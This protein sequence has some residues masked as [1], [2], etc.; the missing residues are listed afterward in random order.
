MDKRPILKCLSE[1]VIKLVNAT[2]DTYFD[3]YHRRLRLSEVPRNLVSR[4]DKHWMILSTTWGYCGVAFAGWSRPS[5]CSRTDAPIAILS[6]NIISKAAEFYGVGRSLCVG[7]V[8]ESSRLKIF[9]DSKLTSASVPVFLGKRIVKH[10][11][12]SSNVVPVLPINCTHVPDYLHISQSVVTSGVKE[13]SK[14]CHHP[15]QKR[16]IYPII[17]YLYAS[18]DVRSLTPDVHCFNTLS[19]CWELKGCDTKH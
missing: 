16:I 13:Q 9:G 14:W 8:V 6:L 18:L 5:R 1:A 10:V 11:P 2:C 3:F 17:C 19:P 12:R 7:E 15:I 4:F